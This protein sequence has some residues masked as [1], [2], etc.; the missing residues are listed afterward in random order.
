MLGLD[1]VAMARRT[2]PAAH[3][4]SRSL[5][6]KYRLEYAGASMRRRF[7]KDA[8][9]GTTAGFRSA[10]AA[11]AVGVGPILIPARPGGERL[12]HGRAGRADQSLRM[13]SPTPIRCSERRA[14]ARADGATAD[15]RTRWIVPA[16]ADARARTTRRRRGV[17]DV[18]RWRAEGHAPDV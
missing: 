2:S 13:S 8:R 7:R 5:R 4:H 11:N 14:L 3:R 9:Q 15:A 16:R 18:A 1:R 12:R 6:V 17:R 10:T